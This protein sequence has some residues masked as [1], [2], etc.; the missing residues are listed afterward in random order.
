MKIRSV[1]VESFYVDGRTDGRTDRQNTD[2]RTDKTKLIVAFCNVVSASTN[3]YVIL[4]LGVITLILK[5]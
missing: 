3:C 4:I 2:R 1:G 5:M